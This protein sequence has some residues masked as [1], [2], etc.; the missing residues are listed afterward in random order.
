MWSTAPTTHQQEPYA[1]MQCVDVSHKSSNAVFQISFIGCHIFAIS[2][3]YD[4]MNPIMAFIGMHLAGLPAMQGR[5]MPCARKG[6]ENRG[7][8]RRGL[9]DL[10]ER[11]EAVAVN[12][13]QR[14]TLDKPERPSQ[15]IPAA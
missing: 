7:G 8:F 5:P 11:R 2:P 1:Q 12:D 9:F 15:K 6:V 4:G 13:T 14:G 3:E 10:H